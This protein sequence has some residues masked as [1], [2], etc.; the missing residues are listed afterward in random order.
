ML[1]STLH[2]LYTIISPNPSFKVTP[3]RPD[4]IYHTGLLSKYSIDNAGTPVS[5]FN[6]TLTEFDE[7]TGKPTFIGHPRSKSYEPYRTLLQPTQS[8]S[9]RSNSLPNS[10]SGLTLGRL[11]AVSSPRSEHPNNRSSR[12]PLK[13]PSRRQS[14]DGRN[15]SSFYDVVC[16]YENSNRSFIIDNAHLA[17]N[18]GV[19]VDLMTAATASLLESPSPEQ[20]GAYPRKLSPPRLR[21]ASYTSGAKAALYPGASLPSFIETPSSSSTRPESSGYQP[22]SHRTRQNENTKHS[23]KQRIEKPTSRKPLS[24][25]KPVPQLGLIQDIAAPSSHPA[26]LSSLSRSMTSDETEDICTSITDSFI[27]TPA[28]STPLSDPDSIFPGSSPSLY[29]SSWENPF[30]VGSSLVSRTANYSTEEEERGRA[31]AR[32]QSSSVRSRSSSWARLRMRST[33]GCSRSKSRSRV[34][35]RDAAKSSKR[36]ERP[37]LPPRPAKRPSRGLKLSSLVDRPFSEFDTTPLKPSRSP[38]SAK[39]NAGPRQ[40]QDPSI[41]HVPAKLGGTKSVSIRKTGKSRNKDD[42]EP[43]HSTEECRD[44]MT[45]SGRDSGSGLFEDQRMDIAC[46]VYAGTGAVDSFGGVGSDSVSG[47]D[48]SG[49][50]RSLKRIKRRIPAFT[51][52]V[53]NEVDTCVSGRSYVEGLDAQSSW[54]VHSNVTVETGAGLSGVSICSASSLTGDP[55]TL[56]S[57]SPLVQDQSYQRSPL[58]V[59]DLFSPRFPYSPP[60]L[61]PRLLP[62]SPP[63]TFQSTPLS[64][65]LPTFPYTVQPSISPEALQQPSRPQYLIPFITPSSSAGSS[66]SS[67][68]ISLESCPELDGDSN[69]YAIWTRTQAQMTQD[70]EG[71]TTAVDALEQDTHFRHG[72]QG[73]NVTR[74]RDVFAG[75]FSSFSSSVHTTGSASPIVEDSRSSQQRETSGPSQSSRISRPRHL[76]RAPML[77]LTFPTPELGDVSTFVASKPV[78]L[79]SSDSESTG[80]TESGIETQSNH[81]RML[82]EFGSDNDVSGVDSQRPR[83]PVRACIT[84]AGHTPYRIP[85]GGSTVPPT[86]PD[87]LAPRTPPKS[88]GNPPFNPNTPPTPLPP[89]PRC[90]AC[91]FGFGL[92]LHQ[93]GTSL[94]DDVIDNLLGRPCKKCAREW[95]KSRRW[96]GK[97]GWDVSGFEEVEGDDVENETKV[98]LK[99]LK[100]MSRRISQLADV[101]KRFSITSY[102]A[103]S[104]NPQRKSVSFAP[105]PTPITSVEECT[106]T[107]TSPLVKTS[108]YS[109]QGQ[110]V[111]LSPVTVI[112]DLSRDSYPQISKE[113]STSTSSFQEQVQDNSQDEDKGHVRPMPLKNTSPRDENSKIKRKN[114][115]LKNAKQRIW[116]EIVRLLSFP[117]SSTGSSKTRNSKRRESKKSWR[118]YS[119]L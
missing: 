46:T 42:N 20:P 18:R 56:I 9:R 112:N 54:D 108:R 75:T 48:F 50:S 14:V 87:S 74:V 117:K 27:Q 119:Y 32:T 31:K 17:A 36:T 34:D 73:T 38:R 90:T 105:T 66:L 33:Q 47:S 22:P 82:G 76:F 58:D 63:A 115:R 61:C 68:D 103:L 4:P 21:S 86:S 91:G 100:R 51:V 8:R 114:K 113:N 7:P 29:E 16:P 67:S 13:D 30:L 88:T 99:T 57:T 55:G 96:Y 102:T 93:S 85:F 89:L 70:T 78:R 53:H 64:F 43:N 10:I 1:D 49:S 62:S 11:S 69:M 107:R 92:E 111:R 95:R 104:S 35:D 28:V 41:V 71:I 60:L 109:T 77:T 52:N 12:S 110:Q 23:R 94:E 84:N 15:T 44:V 19:G 6:R 72:S 39:R 97:R 24:W 25:R 3:S 106:D 80:V 45:G 65:H 98:D 59:S 118:L 26:T 37:P 2:L 83:T 40:K 116:K 81:R 79:S 101:P 5:N